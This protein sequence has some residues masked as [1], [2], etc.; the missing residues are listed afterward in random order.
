MAYQVP[1]SAR[2]LK[3]LD[4][5]S[6]LVGLVLLAAA[7]RWTF[8]EW[9]FLVGILGLVVGVWTVFLEPAE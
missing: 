7:L 8:D 5:V 4:R 1:L 6:K 2:G 9:S 3:W